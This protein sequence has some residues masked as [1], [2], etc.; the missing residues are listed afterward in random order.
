MLLA[1][2]VGIVFFG[3]LLLN[4]F[5]WQAEYP[6][7]TPFAKL[8]TREPF[9]RTRR[10]RARRHRLCVVLV[11]DCSSAVGA[12]AYQLD[13]RRC[14]AIFL[15]IGLLRRLIVYVFPDL[16]Y[17]RIFAIVGIVFA[18]A[19]PHH[20]LFPRE[21]LPSRPAAPLL[22]RPLHPRAHLHHARLG[23]EH[24]GRPRRPARPRL[25][26]LLRGR[27]LYLRAAR[28]A[29]RPRLLDLP[30]DRRRCSPRCGASFSA[31]PCFGCAATISPS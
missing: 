15:A 21:G 9:D 7:T 1:V 27:R 13:R 3:R 5:V 14:V 20:R 24:R 23:P 8:F 31:S 6:I 18:A 16:P 29:F 30:A 25:C 10:H 4:L 12:P 19:L 22:V 2:V 26:R 28:H 17:A 11:F